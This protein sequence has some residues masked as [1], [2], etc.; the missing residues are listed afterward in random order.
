M[1]TEPHLFARKYLRLAAAGLLTA[2]LLAAL[3]YFPTVRLAGG[4][5]AA[6]M[7]A[8]IAVSLTAGL[9]G[10]VPVGLAAIRS[11]EKTPQAVL[12]STTLR[13]LVVLALAA[14]LIL[15]GWFDRAVV[16]VWVGISYIAMLAVD[17]IFAVRLVGA[18][19]GPKS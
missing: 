13:F 5:A 17:T 18:V 19:R 10:A 3:G 8:G 15:S 16:G 14:S 12:L 4:G 6:G 2:L 1:D 7:V 9:I 11:P